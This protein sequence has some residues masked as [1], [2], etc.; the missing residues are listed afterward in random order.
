[1]RPNPFN[2]STLVEFTVGR[3]GDVS[4]TVYDVTGRV[5]RMLADRPFGAGFHTVMWDGK[6]GSGNIA[7]SGV[8][9]VRA[10]SSGTYASARMTL[11]K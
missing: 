8:Y 2:P 3:P 7:S 11:M 1:M 5:V 10:E 6:D 9:I 4:V